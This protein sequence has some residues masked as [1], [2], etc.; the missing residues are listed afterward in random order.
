MQT[1]DIDIAHIEHAVSQYGNFSVLDWLLQEN[2]LPYHQYEA[3]RQG[4]TKHLD[5]QLKTIAD[6]EQLTSTS[7]QHC[8]TLG[9]QPQPRELYSW[10]VSVKTPLKVSAQR[11]RSEGLT[12]QWLRP[13]D[14]PQLDLF[15]DSS[16]V[17]AENHLLEALGARDFSRAD[18][19]IQLLAELNPQHQ[20][21][22]SYQ[23]LINY[24]RHTS[25]LDVEETQLDAEIEGL[26]T[27][28]VP[29]AKEILK[30][31]ARDYLSLAWRRLIGAV[32]DC[33]FD[34]Q[35]PK[36]HRSYLLMQIP[37]WEGLHQTL[38][39]DAQLFEQ[40]E[41]LLRLALCHEARKDLALTQM[42][43]L[44]LLD[45]A[46]DFAE[47]QIEKRAS[48]TMWTLWQDFW[49]VCEEGPGEFFPCFVLIKNPGLVHYLTPFPSFKSPFVSAVI[50]AINTKLEGG[51]E[52]NARKALK[53]ASESLLQ[54][55]MHHYGK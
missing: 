55:F 7:E 45:M 29:L 35:S 38:D 2:Y 21:L 11:Q 39:G 42:C 23:D 15:M 41:L 31:H 28:V 53:S 4:K 37:D 17:V 24:G 1:P 44:A 3:W 22:G 30:H 54:L 40:P 36:R 14:L 18:R 9:L 52:I 26:D 50:Q 27:E 20:R 6:I 32:G 10:D 51:D 19:Q 5:A 25:G 48:K 46:P 16:A 47:T 43:W 13:Q 34:P 8:R 49:E 12:Q 33:K